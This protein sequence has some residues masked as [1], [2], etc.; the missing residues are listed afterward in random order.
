VKG[1]PSGKVQSPGVTKK[2]S[3]LWRTISD[4]LTIT[5]VGRLDKEIARF[6]FF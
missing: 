4:R 1:P 6:A 2:V 3:I 5:I